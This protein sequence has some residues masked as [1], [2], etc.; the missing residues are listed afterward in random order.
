MDSIFTTQSL[1][2]IPILIATVLIS[3]LINKLFLKH[4]NRF[5]VKDLSKTD[6]IRWN[7]ITKPLV[8]G[9]T[10]F[11]LFLMTACAGAFFLPSSEWIVSNQLAGLLGATTLGF[12]VGLLDDVFEMNAW[13]K[14]VGQFACVNILF[15]SGVFIEISSLTSINYLFTSFWVIGIMNSIN[16]LDNM[17]GIT[18]TISSAIIVATMIVMVLTGGSF[19]IYMLLMTG[20]LGALLGFLYYNWNPAKLYMGDTGS[21]FLGAFLAGI[22]MLFLWNAAVVPTEGLIQWNKI[23]LPLVV[24]V[25]PIIDTL[26]VT[27]RRIA[28]GQSPFVGGRDH[29]THNLAVWGLKDYQVTLTFTIISLISVVLGALMV[30]FFSQ[31]PALCL[32]GSVTYFAILFGGIQMVYKVNAEKR[33]AQPTTA[34]KP[35]KPAI[36]PIP[37]RVFNTVARPAPMK[38]AK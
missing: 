26:T 37:I 23:A 25:L 8:G 10:F 1:L 28:R 13:F 33:A 36:E 22:S 27:I 3:I 6:L 17:D 5:G 11:I 9:V 20:V 18:G 19:G 29:T 21:Q 30:S 2:Y 7:S 15:F 31:A 16:M 24:F 34:L 4:A 35:I 12:L 38:K 14:F 32:T